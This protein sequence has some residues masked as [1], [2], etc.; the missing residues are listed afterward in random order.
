M[1]QL[2]AHG[3]STALHRPTAAE[4]GLPLLVTLHG[5]TYTSAYFAVA[6]STGGSFL[7]V[8]ARN[9]FAVLTVDR[10]G[11]GDSDPLPE[12]ENTFARQAEVLD[13]AITELLPQTPAGE[14]V[15]VG[16]SIGGMTALE[17][18][19]RRPSWGLLG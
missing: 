13:A 11:Y 7:D 3:I 5:G 8:A 15:L 16:H 6:G 18:A 12:E 14:V 1:E 9:G 19:A 4:P 2:R 10:P 17:I